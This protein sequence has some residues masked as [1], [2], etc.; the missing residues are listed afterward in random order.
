[1]GIELFLSPDESPC[2]EKANQNTHS[3]ENTRT[4]YGECTEITLG[5]STLIKSARFAILRINNWILWK[6][7]NSIIFLM[8]AAL[9]FFVGCPPLP[10]VICSQPT[11]WTSKGYRNGS[12][13][14]CATT[15]PGPLHPTTVNSNF[16]LPQ[17]PGI[18]HHSYHS[19]RTRSREKLL[20]D[21]SLFS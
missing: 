16:F 11:G 18:A 6:L 2:S 3:S 15:F 1:M 12:P 10:A 7:T 20:N 5:V 17:I 4:L 8:R 13:P 19:P 21:K 14:P 9:F